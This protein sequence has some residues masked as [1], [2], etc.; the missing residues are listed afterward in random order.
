MGCLTVRHCKI[1]APC[2]A[3]SFCVGQDFTFLNAFHLKAILSEGEAALF[4]SLADLKYF[5]YDLLYLLT[6]LQRV[7]VDCHITVLM[8]HCF[9]LC[10]FPFL[11]FS[12]SPSHYS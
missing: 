4:S 9:F 10:F 12:S 5:P 7:W 1:T 11:F 3:A 6:I 8:I 2:T